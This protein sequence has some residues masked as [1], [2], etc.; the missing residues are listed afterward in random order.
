MAN[1][2][3]YASGLDKSD[4][5]R[6]KQKLTVTL[7]D[8]D[9]LLPDPYN[10][11][12]DGWFINPKTL[13]PTTY[14]QLYR[15]LIKTPGP[16]TGEDLDAYKSLDAY[17]YFISGHIKEIQLDPGNDLPVLFVKSLVDAGHIQSCAPYNPS[18]LLDKK[19]GYV[20]TAHCTCM[21]GCGEA[22]SH[23]AAV[24][25]AVE[26]LT[27]DGENCEEA[28]TSIKCIWNNYFKEKVAPATVDTLDFSHPRHGR[29]T[30]I[31]KRK[32]RQR[33]DV[34]SKEEQKAFFKELAQVH[35]NAA[36]LAKGESDTDSASETEEVRFLNQFIY[37]VLLP[38]EG[39][40]W[41]SRF[42]YFCAEF[43]F[44]SRNVC[45]IPILIF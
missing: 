10:K 8:S 11:N 38:P 31:R 32:I 9:V 5:E 40:N 1:L 45:S 7:N 42:T 22:C 4:Q 41:Y 26:Q 15:Y 44:A 2:S 16:F 43:K 6:Y 23:I 3:S 14:G 21:A 18:I 37:S 33:Y 12:L 34:P 24:L 28:K 19:K 25:F 30:T 27:R 29:K 36:C 17:N 20:I 35:P 39:Y 13:P